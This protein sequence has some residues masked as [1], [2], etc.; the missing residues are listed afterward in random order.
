MLI[1]FEKK[2]LDEIEK[3][4]KFKMEKEKEQMEADKKRIEGKKKI[5]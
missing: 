1:L 4:N 3:L 2:K 5:I